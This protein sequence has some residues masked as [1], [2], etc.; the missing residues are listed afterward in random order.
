[1]VLD[2]EYT[3]HTKFVYRL[4]LTCVSLWQQPAVYKARRV[5]CHWEQRPNGSRY[6]VH[7]PQIRNQ[8]HN[9][10]TN[11]MVSYRAPTT[12]IR[13][14]T[15]SHLCL[16]VATA[17]SLQGAES[18]LSL[19]QR[20]NGSRYRV[21]TLNCLQ[22]TAHLCLIVAT[23]GSLQGAEKYTNHTKFVY[24]LQFT[25]VSLWQQPA[26]YKARRVGC[27]WEQRPNGSRYRVHQPH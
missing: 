9:N 12:L 5:G 22:T 18:R 4:Q 27:H 15:T 20:P 21:P 11:L 3:N 26:V 16:I 2:T 23:A 8:P 1:M 6:R 13:L 10:H 7:Q 17:G 14:Q 25:C 24:R 19:E